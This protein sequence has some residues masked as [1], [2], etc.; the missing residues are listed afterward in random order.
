MIVRANNKSNSIHLFAILRLTVCMVSNMLWC[1]LLVLPLNIAKRAR[2]LTH[3]A[4]HHFHSTIHWCVECMHWQRRNWSGEITQ[5][6]VNTEQN[7]IECDMK[8]HINTT[9]ISINTIHANNKQYK[10]LWTWMDFVCYAI[11]K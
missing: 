3:R 11:I 4:R 1:W 10:M 5:Q 8:E 6:T 2:T 7:E 9:S